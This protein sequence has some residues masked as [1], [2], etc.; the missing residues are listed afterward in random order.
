[1][2]IMMIV[3]P[4]LTKLLYPCPNGGKHD[5][6]NRILSHLDEVNVIGQIADLKEVDYKNTL[7]ITALVE[8]LIEKKIITR[9][10]VLDKS[11][12]LENEFSLLMSNDAFPTNDEMAN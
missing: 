1:M 7:V 8:L 4:N 3:K 2:S 11:Y 6:K 5:M 10:E 9:K 12:E